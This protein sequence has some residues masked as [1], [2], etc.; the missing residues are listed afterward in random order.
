MGAAKLSQ[1]L[2]HGPCRTSATSAKSKQRFLGLLLVRPSGKVA[3]II[4]PHTTS[5]TIAAY[6]FCSQQKGGRELLTRDSANSLT[7]MHLPS[8]GVPLLFHK[9]NPLALQPGPTVLRK[10]EVG[11]EVEVAR[12]V[13]WESTS[14]LVVAAVVE[15]DQQNFESGLSLETNSRRNQMRR[16]LESYNTNMLAVNS[17][18]MQIDTL[19]M[20]LSLT[21]MVSNII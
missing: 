13:G 2:E 14:V 8:A 11:G 21:Q 9:W 10:A 20:S 6:Y 12:A 7:F 16:R 3:E 15:A 5:V 1:I 4:S 19:K 18:L 17:D